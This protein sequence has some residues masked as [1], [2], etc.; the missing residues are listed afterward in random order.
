[1]PAIA[2]V[3]LQWG[4]EGKGKVID[5]LS[6]QADYVVRAQ[7]GHNAEQ[8]VHVKQQEIHFFLVPAGMLHPNVCCCLGAGTVI[9][10]NFLLKE[11]EALKK[12]QMVFEKSFFLSPYAHVIFPYHTLLD[13]LEEEQKQK[14]GG[15]IG[16]TK[17]GI[18]PCYTD[19]TKRIGIRVGDLLSPLSFK[20]KLKSNLYQKNRELEQLYGVPGLDFDPI[21]QTYLDCGAQLKKYIVD[22]EDKLQKALQK[23]KIILLEGAQGS[24]LD[25][26]FG[27]YPFATSSSTLSGGLCAGSSI[28]FNQIKKCIGIAKAYCTRMSYGP[29]PTALSPEE[30]KSFFHKNSSV[31]SQIEKQFRRIGWFD[32]VLAKHSI[33]MNGV[34]SLVITKLDVLDHLD[35]V[36]IC[37]GYKQPKV[38][39]F[40]LFG[41]ELFSVEPI[42][43]VFKGW[44]T[45]TKNIRKYQNLPENAKKYL[46]RIQDLCQVPI[47]I[48]SVGPERE[49]T[50][51][52]ESK[53]L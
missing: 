8:T 28:G 41:E 48:V 31:S 49:K 16:T 12:Q 5:L 34:S 27:T 2:V 21:Y 3:G 30:Q 18:G 44:K 35:E 39:L 32:A 37:V 26:N 40:E 50:I 45:P 33:V 17:M 22:L 11:I 38:R 23:E 51:W 15:A 42:Y 46:E 1:M 36:K 47:Q 52:L 29:F 13:R 4:D 43:E 20:E 9:D 7:G 6:Q 10:P 19:K 25:V 24:L 14:T 53:P